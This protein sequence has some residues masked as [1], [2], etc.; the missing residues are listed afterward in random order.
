M[1]TAILTA[2]WLWVGAWSFV[3][4]WTKTDTFTRGQLELMLICSAFGPITFLV[5]W[6]VEK[7]ATK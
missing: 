4:W 7:T 5:G 2:L 1:V 3:Y 6:V